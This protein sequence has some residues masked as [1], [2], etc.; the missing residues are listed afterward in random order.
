MDQARLILSVEDSADDFEA[1]QR[2]F[3]KAGLADGLRRVPSAEE[4]LDYLRSAPQ[5]RPDL[6]LLDLNM[7]GMGGRRFLEVVKQDEAL[8]DTPVVVLTT[9][10]HETDVKKCYALGANTYIVKSLDFAVF[11]AAIRSLKEYWL[12]VAALP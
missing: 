7:P 11:Q 10:S 1:I 8:K 9:S 2:A 6:I 4:A 3:R 5:P 12:E